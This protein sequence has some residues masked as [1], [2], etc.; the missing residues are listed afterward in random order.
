MRCL[1]C[2]DSKDHI[3][4]KCGMKIFGM[5]CHICGRSYGVIQ[6]DMGKWGPYASI[7]DH[8][9]IKDQSHFAPHPSLVSM[10]ECFND[11]KCCFNVHHSIGLDGEI[12]RSDLCLGY[13][14][15]LMLPHPSVML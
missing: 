8:T 1:E 3:H 14:D 5:K 4:C 9:I 10:I 2:N 13:L 15:K 11:T 7:S 6:W 12:Y